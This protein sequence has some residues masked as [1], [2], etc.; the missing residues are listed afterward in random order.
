[1]RR[2]MEKRQ[3][4][5]IDKQKRPI[6]FTQNGTKEIALKQSK[7]YDELGSLNSKLDIMLEH[8]KGATKGN[9]VQ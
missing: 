6:Q 2:K 4:I 3:E 9:A 7:L 8:L 1:M 5:V